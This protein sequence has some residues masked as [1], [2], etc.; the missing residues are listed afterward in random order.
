MSKEKKDGNIDLNDLR[1]LIR[2]KTMKFLNFKK[3]KY[4]GDKNN[5]NGSLLAAPQ[6][7]K[8]NMMM[9]MLKDGLDTELNKFVS[10][11]KKKKNSE[12]NDQFADKFKSILDLEFSK[13]MEGSPDGI[14]GLEKQKSQASHESG[15]KSNRSN[16]SKKRRGSQDI[17][18]EH[19]SNDES[20]NKNQESGGQSKNKSKDSFTSEDEESSFHTDTESSEIGGNV[21]IFIKPLDDPSKSE[22]QS[23]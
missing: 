22:K 14:N 6:K 1:H 2:S 15:G 11:G 21:N 20:S 17:K 7:K 10:D 18:K 19:D 3:D 13:V 16:R 4:S 9:M 12:M 5:N 8:N 23:N